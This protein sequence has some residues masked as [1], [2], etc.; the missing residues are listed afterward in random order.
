MTD[1]IPRVGV[2]LV[3]LGTPTAPR[4]GPIRRYL[5][6]FLSDPR[7]LSIPAPIRWALLNLVILP[8]RPRAITPAYESIWLDEGSPL[9]VYGR[10]LEAAVSE[11]M[12]QDFA[13]TL[14]MRYG[15]PSIP[16]ALETLLAREIDSLVVVP[17]Y[18]QYAAATT[19][20]TL[21]RIYECLGE[22]WNVLPV[23]VVGPF[24][25]ARAFIE[26][27]AR[28]ARETLKDFGADHVLFSYHGLPEA[29]V[30]RSD[31]TGETCLVREGCCELPGSAARGCY[32]AQCYATTR[33]LV[34]ALSLDEG[35]TYST[36][37][38]SRLGRTPWIKP[39][40]DEEV[41]ALRERG[42][43]RLAVLSPAFVADCLE[44][45]EELG[46]RLR[47]QWAE[48]G[49]TDFALVPC[50]NDAPDFAAGLVELIREA[51]PAR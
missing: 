25:D 51:S 33:H 26:P 27:M 43:E 19:G 36:A 22:R 9:L 32:R 14:A 10:S 42:G 12:G 50:V 2:M 46:M 35:V 16:E 23:R 48:L 8:R 40:T 7:V 11:T 37:F 21:S 4:P 24:Y 44:T 41:V 38:Q 18:P 20:S 17:L 47:E 13:V 6:E 31:E 34:D 49:G 29:Q 28:L 15:E 5:R 30:K 1:T 39:Y 45:R 3:N